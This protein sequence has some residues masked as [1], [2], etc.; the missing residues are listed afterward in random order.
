MIRKVFLRLTS[1]HRHIN[2]SNEPGAGCAYILRV[3][4]GHVRASRAANVECIQTENTR[5]MRIRNT[6]PASDNEKNTQQ[7]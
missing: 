1:A 5:G 3:M 7:P 4:V 6:R 2:I